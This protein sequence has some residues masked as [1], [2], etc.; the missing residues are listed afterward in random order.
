[1]FRWRW[2]DL[3]EYL[4]YLI[5]TTGLSLEQIKELR[6]N[7]ELQVKHDDQDVSRPLCSNNSFK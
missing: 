3:D 1:M 6:P 4:V 5:K 7:G 2:K